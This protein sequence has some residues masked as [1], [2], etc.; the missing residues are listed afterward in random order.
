MKTANITDPDLGVSDAV[1]DETDVL[2]WFGH[3]KHDQVPP[4][5]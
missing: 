2:L 5:A 4:E 3:K 1:L